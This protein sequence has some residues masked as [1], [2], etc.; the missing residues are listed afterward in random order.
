MTA[1]PALSSSAVAPAYDPLDWAL[2][3]RVARRVAGREPLAASYL[4]ESLRDEDHLRTVQHD[5]RTLV[6]GVLG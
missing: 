1:A 5:A 4:A 2:A 3:E 6:D